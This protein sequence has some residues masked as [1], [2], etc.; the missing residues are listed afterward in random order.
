MTATA[1][2]AFPAVT[3]APPEGVTRLFLGGTDLAAHL[4]AYGPLR[5]P[6]AGPQFVGELEASGLAGRGG[7]GFPAW[8]KFAAT[9]A[10]QPGRHDRSRPVIIGNGAEGEPRSGKDATLLRHAPHL[11]IDGLLVA[12][13]V[14]RA[15]DIYLYATAENAP[16]ITNAIRERADARRI[17]VVV[18]PHTFI[19]GEASAVAN[20]I[21]HG[22]T[23]PQDRIHRL[24]ERGVKGKPTLVHNVETLAQ[25]A[26]IARFGALW[27]RSIGTERDP[28]TRLLTVTGD[29]AK[30]AVLEV[31]GDTTLSII[32]QSSDT[33]PSSV[34]AVLVG[35]YHGAW[36][37]GDQL[38]TP[39]SAPG[40]APFGAHPGA[41]VI[42][43]LGRDHCGLQAA[44]EIVGYLAGQSARQCGPCTFGLPTL[45]SLLSRLARRDSDPT[46]PTELRRLSGVVTG[47][48]SCH[49]PDGTARFVLSTLS[50]FSSDV[51]A[52]LGGHCECSALLTEGS[53]R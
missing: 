1:S 17:R 52:H 11:V 30:D 15:K 42:V 48:G 2:N 16:F 9:A 12:A 3:V 5:L 38:N 21:E 49:H 47:R 35:G 20:A 50:T 25:I 24:S 7:A 44:A 36:I 51:T 31:A 43:V 46:L 4:V 29:V 23:V 41:G 34:Q 33:S 18:A 27:F 28:G 37:P 40:L 10:A 45:G 8:L 22:R 53:A 6:S 14:L 32:L 39:V 13:A 19:S 26:L